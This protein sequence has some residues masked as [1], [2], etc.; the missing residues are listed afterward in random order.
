MKPLPKPPR[1]RNPFV[2]ELRRLGHKVRP[3]KTVYT[4]KGRTGGAA[5]AALAESGGAA[6]ARPAAG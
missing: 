4:R 5:K 6:P 2:V 1:R 3:S